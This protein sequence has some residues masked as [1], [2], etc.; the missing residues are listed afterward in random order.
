M[1]AVCGA[2]LGAAFLALLVGG[3]AQPRL[4]SRPLTEEQMEWAS[5]IR[6]SY[7]GWKPPYYSTA[8]ERSPDVV[9]VPAAPGTAVAPAAVQPVP[10]GPAGQA[11]FVPAEPSR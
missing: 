3:C 7:P 1:R 8:V 4:A 9:P 11:E 10:A 6:A 2:V 5:Y